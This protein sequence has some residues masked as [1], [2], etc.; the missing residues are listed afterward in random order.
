MPLFNINITVEP[1]FNEV[2]GDRPNLFDKWRVRYNYQ[3][4]RY[5]EILGKTTK[6]FVILRSYFMIDL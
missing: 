5:K 2:V 6:M 4:A 1:Q 3:K